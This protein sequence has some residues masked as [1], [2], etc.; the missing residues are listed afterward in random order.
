MPTLI[1]AGEFFFDLIFFKLQR[2]PRMGEELVTPNFALALG[3]GAVNTAIAAARLGRPVQLAAVLGD[4][5]LDQFALGELAKEG[6]GCDYVSRQRRSMGALTVAVSLPHDRFFLTYPGSNV[7][8]AKYLLA[9]R[10]RNKL[11]AAAHVH[12]GQPDLAPVQR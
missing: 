3:G 5:A 11:S 6:V 2:L 10:T 1:A 8:L 12:F 7:F 4:T 9:P